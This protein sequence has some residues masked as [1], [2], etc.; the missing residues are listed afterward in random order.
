MK[1]V[2]RSIIICTFTVLILAGNTVFS[3]AESNGEAV[4]M[5]DA[6]TVS[7]QKH[8]AYVYRLTDGVYNSYVSY[9]EKQT[10]SAV[11]GDEIGYAYIAWQQLPGKVTLTWLDRNNKTVAT[12]ERSPILMDEY[13]PVPQEGVFGYTLL[14]SQDGGLCELS[15]YTAGA[16]PGDMPQFTAPEKN[17]TVMLIAA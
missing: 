11:C 2:F 5:K 14:F 10:V 13:I 4:E 6:L 17:V 12:E 1:R 8:S 9:E 7:D 15:A 3:V 16:L